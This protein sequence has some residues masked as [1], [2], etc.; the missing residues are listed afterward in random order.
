MILWKIILLVSATAGFL[1][2]SRRSLR[3]PR[4]HGFYR[5]FAWETILILFLLNVSY[6]FDNPYAWYQMFAWTLLFLCI[7]PVVWGAILLHK[8]GKPVEKRKEDPNL[9]AFEKTS[10]LVKSGIYRYIRHP[11]YSSLLLMA[12]GIFFKQ[13]SWAGG[14][15]AVVASG[16]LVLTAQAD[17]AEC[18]QFFGPAY[19]EYMKNTKRFIPF[20]F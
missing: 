7:L 16:F 6:W 15:L 12:W 1:Y 20:L 17:E 5:F 14:T 10:N 4:S 18:I 13:P 9:L 11:L 8:R 19:E 2:I 3:D